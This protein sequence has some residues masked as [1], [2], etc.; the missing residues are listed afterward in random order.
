[1]LSSSSNTKRNS[2]IPR[3]HQRDPNSTTDAEHEKSPDYYYDDSTGYEAYR[4]DDE[5]DTQETR[6]SS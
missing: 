5:D 1:M 2:Q 6:E 4:E 3:E